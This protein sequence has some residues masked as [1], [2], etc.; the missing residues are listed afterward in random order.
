MRTHD[1]HVLMC[2]GPR[3]TENGV[4]AQAVFEFMGDLIDA[5]PELRIKR[6]RTHCMVAC[7]NRGPIVVVYPEG[8]WY[9]G[10]DQEAVRRIVEQH[11]VDGQ[12]VTDLIFH[13]L[14]EGDT[15][16]ADNDP[17]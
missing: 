12:E 16:A 3:C 13:R 4:Q 10:V 11:L 1:R 9:R 14:A 6:T 17:T 15:C 7:R 8:T 5:R 2:V